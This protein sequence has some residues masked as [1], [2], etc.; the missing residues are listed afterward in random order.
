MSRKK[1]LLLNTCTGILK[2]IISIICGFILPRSFLLYYGSSVNGL[3]SSINTFLSFVILL[4]LGVGAVVQ[5]NL[6]KPL[7]DR[8]NDQISR[9]AKSSDTFFRRLLLIFVGYIACLCFFFPKI[10]NFGTWY[11]LSLL[12][13]I[14]VSTIAQSLLGITYQLLLNADQKSYV[15]L[16]MQIVTIV[17]NAISA[18]FLMRA[19]ASI[20]VVKLMTA[21]IYLLRPLGQMLYVRKHYDL[22][23]K[24]KV[25][26]EPIKQKWNGVFQHFAA[27][28]CQ[29][30]DVTVLTLFSTLNNISI[31]TVYYNVT[32]GV[33]Q[34]IMMAAT[35]LESTFGNMIAQGEKQKLRETFS[36]VE[37]IIH[38]AVTIMFSIT[39]ITIVPFISIYTRGITD[40]NYIE[41]TFGVVLVLAYGVQCLRVPY[42]RVIKA[43]GHFKETQNGAFISAVLNIVITVTLVFKFGLVGV[44][45]GTFIAMLYH[46]CYFVWYLSKHIL[47]RPIKYFIRYLITDGV[48]AVGSFM[49][50]S[51][52]AIYNNSYVAWLLFALKVAGIVLLVS[53]AVN[54]ILYR[55]QVK[56]MIKF[57][58]KR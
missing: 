34:I 57:I 42:F 48:I 22:D 25:V 27:V 7:A 17:L 29:N 51:N 21:G 1:K 26:E 43:A 15:Q 2:Q 49:L 23:M 6:Y 50:T 11:T 10:V 52:Y 13:I 39:A 9:I 38:A 40:A 58:C 46:T 4:D 54:L 45:V 33:E 3:I 35:G 12:L 44:A 53:V 8:D 36:V 18:I 16:M 47:E 55:F 32:N 41:P 30:I 28:I 56:A 24:I 20:H 14:S 31:Y 5:A 37:W 19:G